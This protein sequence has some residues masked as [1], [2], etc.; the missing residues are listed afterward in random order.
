[1]HP[2]FAETSAGVFS[3]ILLFQMEEW[4]LTQMLSF[5]QAPWG[6]KE[7]TSVSDVGWVSSY[8]LVVIGFAGVGLP[9]GDGP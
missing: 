7:Q 1:M 9:L 2:V 5:A 3:A 8:V 4:M 6:G